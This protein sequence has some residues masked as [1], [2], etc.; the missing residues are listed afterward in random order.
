MNLIYQDFKD[1]YNYSNPYYQQDL[2]STAIKMHNINE[3]LKRF[4]RDKYTLY[5]NNP[6]IKYQQSNYEVILLLVADSFA[7]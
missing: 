6:A 4:N 7:Y 5:T 2:Q 3:K 1:N